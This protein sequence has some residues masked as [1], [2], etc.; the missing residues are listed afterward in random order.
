MKARVRAGGTPTEQL[1]DVEFR[2][3]TFSTSWDPRETGTALFLEPWSGAE[4]QFTEAERRS[5][6]DATFRAAH[7]QLGVVVALEVLA[8]GLLV[9]RRVANKRRHWLRVSDEH[10]SWLELECTVTVPRVA[11]PA[12]APDVQEPPPV[13]WVDLTAAY[14]VYPAQDPLPPAEQAR[15]GKALCRPHTM[16]DFI[17]TDFEWQFALATGPSDAAG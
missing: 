10:V 12:L 9:I 6:L 15:I 3:H 8:P 2:G 5:V 16:A 11:R 4:D 7:E 14:R 13:A 1:I 17:L